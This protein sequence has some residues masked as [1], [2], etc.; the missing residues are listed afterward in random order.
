M[1]LV[2]NLTLDLMDPGTPER[3]P[4]KQGDA[5]THRLTIRLLCGGEAWL[6]PAGVTPVVRW[7]ACDP[8][9]GGSAQGIFDTLPNGT[10]AWNC[11]ENQ[12]DL[13]LVPQMFALPGIVQADVALI[14]EDKTL[15]TA[16]FEF[17][18][19]PAPANGTEPQAQDYY[20]VAT[21]TQING[22]LEALEQWRAEADLLLTHLEE[23]IYY[24]KEEV[25]GG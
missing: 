21:L 7:R 8:L 22:A 14:Q 12:L 4:V 15:A 10:H 24:L 17:Y 18:V 25:F 3:I 5:L 1:M 6:I 23:D 19:N 16:N 20:K 2:H 11:A 9:S 13:V